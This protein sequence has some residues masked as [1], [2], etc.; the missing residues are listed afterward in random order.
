MNKIGESR[1]TCISFKVDGD[2]SYILL[3][4]RIDGNVL[5]SNVD[6]WVNKNKIEIVVGD[7]KHVIKHN[8]AQWTVLFISFSLKSNCCKFKYSAN[9]VAGEFTV[10]GSLSP[11]AGLILGGDNYENYNFV[12][13]IGGLFIHGISNGGEVP[14]EMKIEVMKRL[15]VDESDS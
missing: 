10:S 11:H 9:D 2:D 1:H 14:E 6:I 8:C 15:K 3:T 12:G 7:E 4:N 5:S 13:D